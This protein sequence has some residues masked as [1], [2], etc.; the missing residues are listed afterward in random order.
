[1]QKYSE[2]SGEFEFGIY[3]GCFDRVPNCFQQNRWNFM[4]APPHT[5]KIPKFFNG[6]YPQP[7]FYGGGGNPPSFFSGANCTP[8]PPQNVVQN[9]AGVSSICISKPAGTFLITLDANV[10][11]LDFELLVY[12]LCSRFLLKMGRHQKTMREIK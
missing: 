6:G 7:K 5:K 9:R 2:L 1:M 8:P 3:F 4:D 10:I 12:S 11:F